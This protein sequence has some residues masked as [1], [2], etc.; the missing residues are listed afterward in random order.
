MIQAVSFAS[1]KSNNAAPQMQPAAKDQTPVLIDKDFEKVLKA[2]KRKEKANIASALGSTMVTQFAA[3]AVF[4][5]IMDGI[6]NIYRAIKKNKPLISLKEFAANAAKTGGI[7]LGFGVA[8]TLAFW[9]LGAAKSK[10][11][12]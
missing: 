12:K 2:Q 3:G 9:L 10:K 1:Q 7:F 4:S 6:T 5:G 11:E 8:L